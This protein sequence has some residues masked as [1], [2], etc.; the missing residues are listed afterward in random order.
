MIPPVWSGLPRGVSGCIIKRYE[1]IDTYD[2]ILDS[3]LKVSNIPI[4]F[5]RP[6]H[7]L[8]T[9]KNVFKNNTQQ[10]FDN[11]TFRMPT[12]QRRYAW[13]QSDWMG[14]W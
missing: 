8:C 3:G 13:K 11:R 14:V 1:D 2:I 12:Y 6:D 5:I 10:L 9:G 4:N 7:I